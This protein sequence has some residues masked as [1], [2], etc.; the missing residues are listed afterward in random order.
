MKTMEFLPWS[1]ISRAQTRGYREQTRRFRFDAD[2]VQ[3]SHGEITVTP[4][5]RRQVAA[6]IGEFMREAGV[7]IAVLAPIELLVTHGTLTV[8]GIL[9]IVGIAVPCLV[10]GVILGLERR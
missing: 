3:L 10:D 8:K 1:R 9:V 5:T 6:M 4:D 2:V 7:L